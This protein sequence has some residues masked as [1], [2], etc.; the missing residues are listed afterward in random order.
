MGTKWTIEPHG[1]GYALYSGRGPMQHGMNLLH[2]S[3]P[4]Q[5]WETTKRLIEAAP[6]MLQ[7]LRDIANH[8]KQAAGSMATLSTTYLLAIRAIEKAGFDL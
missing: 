7:A 6:N 1:D 3:E 5:S 4:D 8:Q 2:M